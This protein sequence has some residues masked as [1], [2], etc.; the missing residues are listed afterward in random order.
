MYQVLC[1]ASVGIGEDETVLQSTLEEA[2]P[3]VVGKE[4]VTI[5]VEEVESV[6]KGTLVVVGEA[7]AL[8]AV[9]VVIWE[10]KEEVI[11]GVRISTR[12]RR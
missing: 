9:G 10:V 1:E 2:I 6:A 5:V 3:V 8:G 12:G 11:V 4:V 7:L